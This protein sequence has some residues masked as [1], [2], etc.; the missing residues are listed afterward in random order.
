MVAGACA[1][2]AA[3]AFTTP[4]DVCKTL[5]NTQE[6]GVGSTKGLFEAVRKVSL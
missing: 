4:L 1:G 6:Q 3:A 2:A 5:L